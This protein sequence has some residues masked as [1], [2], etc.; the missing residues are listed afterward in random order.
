MKDDHLLARELGFLQLKE[1]DFGG[2]PIHPQFLPK[3]LNPLLEAP[4]SFLE[5]KLCVAVITAVDSPAVSLTSNSG[6]IRLATETEYEMFWLSE[7][8]A[9]TPLLDP[10]FGRHHG[11]LL[12]RKRSV[13]QQ[14]LAVAVARPAGS[15]PKGIRTD[16]TR[17]EELKSA[18]AGKKAA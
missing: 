10:I 16:Q 13:V 8:C 15:C 1:L 3:K 18:E 17:S 2:W 6:S 9:V 7:G 4:L 14:K 11:K 12:T 5:Q